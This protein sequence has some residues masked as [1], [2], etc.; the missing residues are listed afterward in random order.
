[1]SR[2]IAQ[3]STRAPG[4]PTTDDSIHARARAILA[5]HGHPLSFAQIV[6][7][8]TAKHELSKRESIRST[9]SR[10]AKN[11]ETFTKSDDRLYGLLEWEAAPPAGDHSAG[12]AQ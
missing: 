3:S 8:Y 1:M 11:G 7:A 9:L 6:S 4:R 12:G 2:V 5:E 10:L